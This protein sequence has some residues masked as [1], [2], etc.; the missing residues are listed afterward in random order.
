VRL[1]TFGAG[2]RRCEKVVEA[3]DTYVKDAIGKLLNIIDLV[4]FCDE[5]TEIGIRL[6]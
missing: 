6:P 2:Y 5:K 4:F 3:Q 1:Y